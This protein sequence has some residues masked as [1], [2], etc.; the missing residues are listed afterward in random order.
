[1][2]VARARYM[3]MAPGMLIE[4]YGVRLPGFHLPEASFTASGTPHAA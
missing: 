2:A 1:M 4:E 3:A